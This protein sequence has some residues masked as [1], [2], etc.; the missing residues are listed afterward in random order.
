MSDKSAGNTFHFTPMRLVRDNETPRALRPGT[1]RRLDNQLTRAFQNRYGA[2]QGLRVVVKLATLEL[3]RAGA[4]RDEIKR[5]LAEV[6][7]AH[8]SGGV[9]R[10]S[11]LTGQSRQDSLTAMIAAWSDRIDDSDSNGGG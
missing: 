4:S 6:L 7:S 8:P 5:T 3:L 2:E 1:R 11:L 9:T 10:P